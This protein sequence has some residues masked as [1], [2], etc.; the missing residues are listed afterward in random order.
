MTNWR[1]LRAPERQRALKL[2]YLLAP[3][4]LFC[5]VTIPRCSASCSLSCVKRTQAERT[6]NEAAA[7]L[8]S[9][10]S[11]R[12]SHVASYG[13]DL[14]ARATFLSPSEE[15]TAADE[16][17]AELGNGEARRGD[18]DSKADLG[19]K[20]HKNGCLLLGAGAPPCCRTSSCGDGPQVGQKTSRDRQNLSSPRDAPPASQAAALPVSPRSLEAVE[21]SPDVLQKSEEIAQPTDKDAAETA[22]EKGAQAIGS[23]SHPGR[24]KRD[25]ERPDAPQAAEATRK[26]LTPSGEVASEAYSESAPIPAKNLTQESGIESAGHE[27]HSGGQGSGPGSSAASA[28]KADSASKT[29]GKGD[30]SPLAGPKEELRSSEKRFMQVALP[31]VEDTERHALTDGATKPQSTIWE[32]RGTDRMPKAKDGAPSSASTSSGGFPM[33]LWVLMVSI[34]GFVAVAAV[35]LLVVFVFFRSHRLR[36]RKKREA[37]LMLRKMIR[38]NSVPTPELVSRYAREMR[39]EDGPG[40]RRCSLPQSG[41]GKAPLPPPHGVPAAPKKRAGVSRTGFAKGVKLPF[42]SRRKLSGVAQGAPSG[43]A[44]ERTLSTSSS[45]SPSRPVSGVPDESLPRASDPRLMPGG[46]VPSG[47]KKAGDSLGFFSFAS[48]EGTAEIP[49]SPAGVL[50]VPEVRNEFASTPSPQ[51]A[52]RGRNKWVVVARHQHL[53]HPPQNNLGNLRNDRDDACCGRQT[54]A[55][56]VAEDAGCGGAGGLEDPSEGWSSDIPSHM[57]QT[58]IHRETEVIDEDAIV[59]FDATVPLENTDEGEAGEDEDGSVDRK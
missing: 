47:W 17:E 46:V 21:S 11:T 6:E 15:R 48:R 16:G 54:W 26:H 20:S 2:L 31:A 7:S 4:L 30:S 19:E 53:F 22:K 42:R 50:D 25:T 18:V 38:S 23:H 49:L 52:K 37:K 58:A 51:E 8:P 36:H 56:E 10:A 27:K 9:S 29:N 12:D 13:S 59:E 43:E 1:R 41:G 57:M 24:Q 45:L 28:E 3:Y 5:G 34:V 35:G 33:P 32:K 14:R 44:R 39:E 40:E 55:S